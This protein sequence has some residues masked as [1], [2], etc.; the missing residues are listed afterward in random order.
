ML[1]G[2]NTAMTAAAAGRQTVDGT[3]DNDFY[4]STHSGD[5]LA[6]AGISPESPLTLM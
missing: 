5:R 6:I 1:V 3:T 2:A 4:H